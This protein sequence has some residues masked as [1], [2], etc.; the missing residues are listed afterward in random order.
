MYSNVLLFCFQQAFKEDDK[1]F[2]LYTIAIVHNGARYMPDM[3]KLLAKTY[4]TLKVNTT[5]LK[6]STETEFSDLLSYYKKVKKFVSVKLVVFSII[7]TC[8]QIYCDR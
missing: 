7:I 2:A 6:S 3:L 8:F 1:G 5:K 4:P